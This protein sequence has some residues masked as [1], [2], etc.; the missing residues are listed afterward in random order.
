MASFESRNA[1]QPAQG[2]AVV[3][4]KV[5]SYT[6]PLTGG[7]VWIAGLSQDACDIEAL[8]RGLQGPGTRHEYFDRPGGRWD[9]AKLRAAGVDVVLP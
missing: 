3:K 9:E 6:S 5:Y 8:N 7:E 1:H 4:R 2:A